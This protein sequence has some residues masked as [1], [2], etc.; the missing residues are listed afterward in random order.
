MRG[1]GGA[2]S[3]EP[4]PAAALRGGS[5]AFGVSGV[6]GLKTERA[7]V[8]DAS[9]AMC[10]PLGLKAGVYRAC[11][12]EIKDGGA[13]VRWR[14][15]C[16]GRSAMPGPIYYCKRGKEV[17]RVCVELKRGARA[18]V[19]CCSTPATAELRRQI[20]GDVFPPLGWSTEL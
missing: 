7:W 15:A 8:G 16:A 3:P 2:E 10:D 13:P 1:G 4:I 17:P 20:T 12:L 6:P 11:G 5:P 14:I 9:H 18:A 19:S